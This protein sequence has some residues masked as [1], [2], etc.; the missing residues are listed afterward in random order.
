[1]T[2][3]LTMPKFTHAKSAAIYPLTL[4]YDGDCPLCTLEIANLHDRDSDRRLRMVNIAD[5][6][7]DIAPYASK[8]KVNLSDLMA[9]IHAVQ[10]DGQLV[11]GVAVFRLAYGAVGLGA[12]TR[13]TS[14][15]LLKPLFD[16][17]YT[18][19]A[20]HRYTV[21]R[22]LGP[23][24]SRLAAARALRQSQA[25]ANGQACSHPANRRSS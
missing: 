24:I 21:S 1:M 8:H 3:E 7:F 13:P 18:H 15:P 23:L 12:I 20:R 4:L 16:W 5:P 19:F 14:W 22:F 25:C 11:R 10:A 6:N 9:M 17:G 2:Q